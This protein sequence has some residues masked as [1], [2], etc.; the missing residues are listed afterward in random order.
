MVEVVQEPVSGTSSQP[1]MWDS[2]QPD[3][4]L[5]R[6]HQEATTAQVTLGAEE[7]E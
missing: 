6:F 5:C 2:F 4:F 1:L 3:L 7:R